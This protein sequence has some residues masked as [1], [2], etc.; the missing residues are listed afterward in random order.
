MRQVHNI[1][2]RTV[3]T[4]ITFHSL[5]NMAM[6]E[7]QLKSK[8]LE[9]LMLHFISQ[10][11]IFSKCTFLSWLEISRDVNRQMVVRQL[12]NGNKNEKFHYWK[13]T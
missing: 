11:L 12:I 10:Q 9:F 7:A 3:V 8:T 2:G 5:S 1:R 6:Q 13:R 4:T